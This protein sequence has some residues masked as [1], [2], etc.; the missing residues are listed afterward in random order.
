MALFLDFDNTLL[1]SASIYEFSI[2][3]LSKKAKEYGL[4]STKEFLQLYDEARKEAKL[5]LQDSP[6]NRLRLIYFKKMCLEKWETLN[7]KWI[8]KLEKDYFYFFQTGIQTFKKKYEKEY[9][10][11]F[12]LLDQISQ[13]QKILFCTNEN[14]RTQLIK[15]DF[16]FPKK[17]KYSILSS[18][19]IG[20]EKPSEKFFAKARELV[21]GENPVSMIGDSLKDDV[22]GALRHGIPAI[23]LKSI[24][25]KKQNDLEERRIV[26]ADVPKKNE[27]SYLETNDL[28]AALKLFL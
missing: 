19:E 24:F 22:E 3:E 26:L 13:K 14:L 4:T 23:H 16:L 2:Q 10:E 8:L 1:D 17:L 21:K 7:P 18:E 5:E 25:S 9:K 15:I 6:S 12:S 20:K 28:R 27:Y 11:T